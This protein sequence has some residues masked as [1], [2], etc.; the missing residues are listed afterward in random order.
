MTRI[1]PLTVETASQDGAQILSA[2]KGKIGMVP[3]LYASMAHSPAALNAA[4]AFGDAM[5]NS[6]LSPAVKEQLALVIAGANSC[7]Y[8]ASAHT[9]IGKGAGVAADELARNLVGEATD[10]KVQALLTLAKTIVSNRGSISDSDLSTA[11]SAGVTEGEIVE[12]VASVAINT[13]TNYFNHIAET[14]IDFP[15]VRT[16]AAVS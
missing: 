10:P 7:D 12:V 5:G 11:R 6:I 4:L 14:E 15:V 13:F 9:A 1:Q 2:I 16:G 3:N 8:C